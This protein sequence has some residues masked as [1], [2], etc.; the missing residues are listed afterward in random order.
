MSATIAKRLNF[1]RAADRKLRVAVLKRDGFTC[2]AC[3]WQ[4][5][6][7]AIPSDYDGR[8]V[9]GFWPNPT[10]ERQLQIDHMT[11]RSRGGQNVLSNLQTLCD[12]CNRRKAS[13]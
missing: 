13:K 9:I 11:A 2:C 6:A 3:G 12:P 7:D 1:R 5:P 4:P 10:A 8:Y